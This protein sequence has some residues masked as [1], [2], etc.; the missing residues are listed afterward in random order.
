MSAI[1]VPPSHPFILFEAPSGLRLINNTYSFP[2]NRDFRRFSPA[3]SLPVDPSCLIRP[4]HLPSFLSQRPLPVLSAFPALPVPPS[5]PAPSGPS[6][7]PAPSAPRSQ[8]VSS[9]PSALPAPSAPRSQPASS[10]PLRSQR[11][12]PKSVAAVQPVMRTRTYSPTRWSPRS[13]TTTLF[14]DVRPDS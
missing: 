13:K 9:G 7:L 4:R 6:A 14:C 2:G 12:L 8:P 3:P 1:V 10:G 11:A 5:Q